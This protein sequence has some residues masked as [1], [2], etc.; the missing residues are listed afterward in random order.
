MSGIAVISGENSPE[1]DLMPQILKQMNHRGPEEESIVEEETFVLG[2][3]GLPVMEIN[4]KG[5][6]IF[7]NKENT[8]I[9]CNGEIYNHKDLRKKMLKNHD[10]I[11]EAQNETI[12]SL[13]QQYGIEALNF[14]D[15]NFAF[16]IIDEGKD[17][18]K[19]FAARD[20]LGVKPL[21]FGKKGGKIFF[22]SELKSL[23]KLV[24]ELE[25]FPPGHYYTPE[26]GFV[27][28]NKIS[29]P[30]KR[31]AEKLEN[32]EAVLENIRKLTNQAIK[33]TLEADVPVGLLLSGGLDSSLIAAV[34]TAEAKG[35]KFKSFCVGS[36][37]SNDIPRAREVARQLGT[38]HHEYIYNQEELVE[39]I[40]KIIYYL[41]SFDPSLVRSAIP[42]Y[43]V[44]RL[45]AQHVKLVLSGEGAD[46][47]FNGY[48]YLK[49][50]K[51]TEALDKEVIRV[52]QS[53]HNIGLQRGDRMSM[54]NSVDVRA[55]FLDKE[56]MDYALS[57]P[58]NWKIYG[59]GDT[60]IEKWILR[61]AFDGKINLPNDVLWRNKEEFSEGSG[62]KDEM[63]S[64]S[65]QV[66]SDETFQKEKLEI[67]LK[68]KIN[69]R[70]KEELY[71]YKIFKEI[72]PQS[73]ITKTVGRWAT[74]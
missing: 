63:Q 68:D 57:I 6:A 28:Y 40:P 74:V 31:I 5:K 20:T 16:I 22:A 2:Y 32:R 14:L 4:S 47:L 36:K 67:F 33:K 71:Y 56:L 62:A 8:Y 11:S 24:D 38:D 73:Y 35:K 58:T 21:Y 49:N 64:Y 25:E 1:G 13:Y 15:G 61:K 60:Q 52:L 23:Y 55:P 53:V 19:L 7:T 44:F 12:L 18:S 34:A 69:I 39:A 42:C 45:A 59:N 66:I 48:G 50:I 10:F 51:D 9:V 54:A 72:Y 41:E 65:E 46:E 26:E 27:E 37:N 70:S 3:K 17:K 29:F 43:F 30:K